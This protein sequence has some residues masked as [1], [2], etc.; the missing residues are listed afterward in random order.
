MNNIFNNTI[1]NKKD[2]GRC[3]NDPYCENNRTYNTR[4]TKPE[5]SSFN[6]QFDFDWGFNSGQIFGQENLF[7]NGFVSNLFGDKFASK[8]NNKR[9]KTARAKPQNA[10]AS[11][12][13]NY[14]DT[15]KKLKKTSFEHDNKEN[16]APKYHQNINQSNLV[17]EFK[18]NTA[19]KR[20]STILQS[21]SVNKNGKKTTI[22]KK[23]YKDNEKSETFVTKITEDKN[24]CKNV[25]N[26]NPANYN[27]ER[28]AMMERME[29]A[30]IVLMDITE[31]SDSEDNN[32]VKMLEE[33][34]NSHRS[35]INDKILNTDSGNNM[36]GIAY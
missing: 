25:Q 29:E 23:Q 36:F 19:P 9:A 1:P 13:N 11:A 18:E 33:H 35:F 14:I 22:N 15:K 2:N 16:T 5:R 12:R 3:C 32:S 31:G 4:Q 20:Y 8:D 26:I 27:E 7:N 17:N 6:K 10:P 28:K 34:K 21:N 30:G 24:G